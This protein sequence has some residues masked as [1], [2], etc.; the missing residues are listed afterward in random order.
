MHGK[1]T[2]LFRKLTR[3]IPLLPSLKTY[4]F[5]L[6]LVIGIVPSIILRI[7]ILESYEERA[8]SLRATDVYTQ[9]MIIANH[10]LNYNYLQGPTSEVI[11]AELEQMSNLYEV[12]S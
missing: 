2:G 11:N 10:L 7:G 6:M 3:K 9:Y 1:K 8:V 5:V 4:I 12:G